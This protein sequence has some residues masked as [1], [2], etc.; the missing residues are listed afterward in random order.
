MALGGAGVSHCVFPDEAEY[1]HSPA[2]ASRSGGIEIKGSGIARSSAGV[3][4]ERPKSK[5]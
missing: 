2:V 3:Q 1:G 5:T 4:S